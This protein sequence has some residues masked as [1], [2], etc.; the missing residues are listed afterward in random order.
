MTSVAKS[1]A[2]YLQ[3]L[4]EDRRIA[5]TAVRKV[6]LKNLPEGYEECMQYGA[7]SYV[8]PHR[9]YPAGYH[10][11]PRQPLT[12]AMLASQKNHMALHLLCAYGDDESI[13]WLQKEFK[14]AGKKLDMGKACLRFKK[15]EDLPLAV[16]GK[17]VA[18]IPVKKYI[19]RMEKVLA[20]RRL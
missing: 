19:S 7:I 10:C 6:F 20:K 13:A 17:F 18:R 3:G 1:P 5:L 2:E 15:L 14:A 9:L 8:V 16:I 11:D 12:F 4:P